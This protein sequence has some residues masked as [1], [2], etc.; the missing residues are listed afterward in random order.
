MKH[1]FETEQVAHLWMHQAQADA[2]NA[3]GNF[4][5][6]G[7]TI[8]SY[9]RHFPIARHVA[10][11]NGRRAILFTTSSYS[12]TT[13][14]QIGIVRSAIHGNGVEVFDVSNPGNDAP[15]LMEGAQA[16]I[17]AAA[18][19]TGGK[20]SLRALRPRGRRRIQERL[21]GPCDRECRVNYY[22]LLADLAALVFVIGIVRRIAK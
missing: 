3:L 22:P 10:G 4:Y 15:R 5:F 20:G 13:S 6:E 19:A 7:D 8:Y 11:V 2:R 18:E 16:R 17:K 14:R 1:V 12:K 9:G 21:F